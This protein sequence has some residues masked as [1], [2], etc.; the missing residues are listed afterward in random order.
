M[1]QLLWLETLIKGVIG[2]SLLL[3]PKM[4]I[5]MFALPDSSSSFWPRL[6]GALLVG[7]AGVIFMSGA[8]LIN[9]GIGLAGLATLNLCAA[10]ILLAT[11]WAPRPSTQQRGKSL[12]G[13]LGLALC[14]LAIVELL[15]R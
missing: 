14:L 9:D 10:A 3:S 11:Y 12:L 6:T 15:V 8:K 2:I 1:E 5:R 7:L 13:G 4:L